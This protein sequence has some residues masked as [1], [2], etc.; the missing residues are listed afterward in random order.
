MKKLIL[1]TV[2]T[3][4]LTGCQNIRTVDKSTTTTTTITTK[5][6]KNK[7]DVIVKVIVVVVNDILTINTGFTLGT[8]GFGS[9][10]LF[11]DISFL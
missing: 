9:Y 10:S 4:L 11:R 6:V 8:Q 3:M 5:K 7:P 1:L 2:L